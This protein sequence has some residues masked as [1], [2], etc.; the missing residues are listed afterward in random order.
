[1]CDLRPVGLKEED[2][3]NA[4]CLICEGNFNC[5]LMVSQND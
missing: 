2:V 4:L 5:F 1:M 3:L